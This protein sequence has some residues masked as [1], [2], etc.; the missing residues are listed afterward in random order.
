M[1][2]TVILHNKKFQ[3]Y[4]S[5]KEILEKIDSLANKINIDFKEKNPIFLSILNGAFMFTSDLMKKISIPCEISFVKISSY[6]QTKSTGKVSELIGLNKSLKDR[7]VLII[8]DI[9]D[10]GTSMNSLIP[11]IDNQQPKSI[12]LITLLHK[13][14]ALKFELPIKYIAFNIPN[15][16]VIGYGLDFDE[17][18]RNLPDIYQLSE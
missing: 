18:G 14:E 4:I 9:I 7:H 12:E 10:T 2:N 11:I 13:P 17:Q 1:N 5:E 6:Q 15:K 3:K 16:F 8:E